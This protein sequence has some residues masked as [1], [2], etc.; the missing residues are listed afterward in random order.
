MPCATRG[1]GEQIDEEEEQVREEGTAPGELELF[2]Q[3]EPEQLLGEQPS[4]LLPEVW[5]RPR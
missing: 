5:P 3:L 2:Y 1:E 4:C